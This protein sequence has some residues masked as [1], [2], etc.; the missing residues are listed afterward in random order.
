MS[1]RIL[2]IIGNPDPTPERLCRALARSTLKVRNP[3]VT[4][5]N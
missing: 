3:L 2:V 1:K 4:S 5:C